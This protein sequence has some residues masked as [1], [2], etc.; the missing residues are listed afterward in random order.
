MRIHHHYSG[1]PKEP[2]FCCPICGW[3]LRE[4]QYQWVCSQCAL[5][6]A[7]ISPAWQ[8]CTQRPAP[9]SPCV[10]GDGVG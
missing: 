8:L 2:S 3:P 6:F 5:P 4:Q 7:A 1:N 9:T 10:S